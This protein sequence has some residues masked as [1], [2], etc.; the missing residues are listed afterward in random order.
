ME[1]VEEKIIFVFDRISNIFKS[2]LWDIAFKYSLT[3]L[4][5]QILFFLRERRGSRVMVSEV[6]KELGIT[7]ATVSD[8]L[9][10]LR[11]KGYITKKNLKKDKRFKVLSLTNTGIEIAEKGYKEWEREILGGLDK[12]KKNDKERLFRF[13][14][15]IIMNYQKKG[16]ISTARICLNCENFIENAYPYTSKPHYCKFTD[17]RFSDSGIKVYCEENIPRVKVQSLKK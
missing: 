12:F 10:V 7:T 2:I 8:S 11:D 9:R 14:L 17:R 16:I 5:F 6:A 1:K 15:S 4:Q 3:P 13:L